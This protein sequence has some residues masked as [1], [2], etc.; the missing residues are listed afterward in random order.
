MGKQKIDIAIINEVYSTVPPSI[1][2]YTW[3]QARDDRPFRGSVIYV[4]STLA[5]STTKVPDKSD[6]ED[7][8]MIHL[9]L[10][11]LPALHIIGVYLDCAPTVEQANKVQ[12][13]LE[14]KLEEITNKDED[15]LLMG[16]LNRRWTNPQNSRRHR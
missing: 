11:T 10:N 13:R 1:R 3:Y 14:A 8:E 4:K 16:D 5:G 9:R 12:A 6:E 7:L 15:V 2:G